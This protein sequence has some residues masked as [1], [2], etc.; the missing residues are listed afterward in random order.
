MIFLAATAKDNNFA[1]HA[2]IG[3]LAATAV[4]IYYARR[5]P[6]GH[7]PAA[8]RSVFLD[9][10]VNA[11]MIATVFGGLRAFW[12]ASSLPCNSRS[13]CSISTCLGP[14]L[15]VSD[16]FIHRRSSLHL[17]ETPR[18]QRAFMSSSAPA[19]RGLP[20]ATS[21]GSYS[22]AISSSSSSRRLV[23]CLV[24]RNRANMRNPSGM[25]IFG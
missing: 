6:N 1:I 9:G 25:S 17:A 15:A 20:S 3:F 2:W 12:L 24:S 16:H 11:G 10:V 22:G 14:I 23:I 21:P 13:R 5:F 7:S 8:G 4:I 18:L 19:A